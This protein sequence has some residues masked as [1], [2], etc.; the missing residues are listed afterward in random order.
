LAVRV[1]AVAKKAGQRVRS[2]FSW[3]Q[4]NIKNN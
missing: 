1:A 4:L 3:Q 2:I